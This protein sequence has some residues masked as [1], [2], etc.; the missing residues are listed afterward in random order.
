LQ[1][2][3]NSY[4]SNYVPFGTLSIHFAN[5]Q[6]GWIYGSFY[7][8]ASS[9]GTDV[10]PKTELWASHDG[11][12]S[13]T[14]VDA[15]AFG[16]K[17]GV[18]SLSS[19]GGQVYALAWLTDQTFG[20]WRS[21]TAAES[22]QTVA[23]PSL[24]MAAGGTSME[25]ALVFKGTSGWL[26]VGNDRGVTGSARLN[27]RGQ[28]VKWDAPCYSVGNG[29]VVPVA[30]SATSLIDVCTIGGFGGYVAPSTPSYVKPESNWIYSSNNGGSS[31]APTSRVVINNSSLNL[32]LYYGIPASPAPGVVLM[33]KLVGLGQTLSDHLYLSRDRGKTWTLVYATP[34][35]P[36]QQMIQNAFFASSKLGSAI[37]QTTDTSSMLII[38]SDGGKTWHK[39][40]V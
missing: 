24:P 27:S 31:F 5:R 38:S 11:G 30:Y 17:F 3:I 34:F 10:Q 18:L 25:A 22:W 33:T 9:T 13:W 19:N 28:W 36:S 6:D 8:S 7:S 16:M 40:T 37:V 29:F 15:M 2:V 4:N 1:K 12:D 21:S 35:A 39:S 26:M 23:T 32:S 14:A 20:L